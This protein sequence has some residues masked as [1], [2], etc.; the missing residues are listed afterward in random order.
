MVTRP[1]R[2]DPA[3]SGRTDAEVF[4]WLKEDAGGEDDGLPSNR[5][6]FE[7]YLREARAHYD[8]HKHTRRAGRA[9]GRSVARA[10]E[11]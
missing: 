5:E 8:T 10:S 7:R 4:H 11:L 3:L 9:T 1:S 2:R 6:T